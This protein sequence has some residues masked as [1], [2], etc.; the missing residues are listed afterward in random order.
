MNAKPPP[1]WYVMDG[2]PELLH[3]WDGTQ[4]TDATQPLV[5]PTTPTAAEEKP[6]LPGWY[7]YRDGECLR[8]WGGTRWTSQTMPMSGP[9]EPNGNWWGGPPGRLDPSGR[10][11]RVARYAR[12]IAEDAAAR[13]AHERASFESGLALIRAR[14]RKRK[15]PLRIAISLISLSLL[16]GCYAFFYHVNSTSNDVNTGS[17]GA[18]FACQDFVKERLKSPSTAKF[19]LDLYTAVT[20]VGTTYVVKSYVDADNS[21]GAPIRSSYVCEV[22]NSGGTW[23][24]LSLTG[25]G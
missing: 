13:K 3:W 15:R 10:S 21:F 8:Y 4:W 5:S 12:A 16:G 7:R 17:S 14:D 23:T 9:M 20:R 11:E 18:Y 1:G 6:T 19:P 22:Q 2:Q 25:L 24:L